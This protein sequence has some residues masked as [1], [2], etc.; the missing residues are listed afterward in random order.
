MFAGG[1]RRLWPAGLGLPCATATAAG[2]SWLVTEVAGSPCGRPCPRAQPLAEKPPHEMGVAELQ[3]EMAVGRL[4]AV[5]S[6]AHFVE[7]IGALNAHGPCLRAVV[8]MNP[9]VAE[10]AAQADAERAAGFV[11]GPLHG[12]CVL[13]KENIDTADGMQT[14]AG[15]LALLSSRPVAD[16]FIV[17]RLRAAGALIL[18]KTN[19]SEWANFRSTASRS[20]W[21][22]PQRTTAS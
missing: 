9:D 13:L 19:L 2:I 16:A 18:G 3:R 12:V 5:A 8:E 7:R 22:A 21:S 14:T 10:Q 1:L 4:T 11:R 20:G 6:A 17:S 15:S